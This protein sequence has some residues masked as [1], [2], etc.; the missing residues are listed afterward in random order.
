[1]LSQV[2]QVLWLKQS[3]QLVIQSPQALQVSTPFHTILLA[4]EVHVVA[5]GEQVEQEGWQVVQVAPPSNNPGL[6]SQEG[7]GVLF[8]A[9]AQVTQS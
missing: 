9:S 8:P 2:V 5:L 6:Q 7:A 1:M 3:E 4:Q